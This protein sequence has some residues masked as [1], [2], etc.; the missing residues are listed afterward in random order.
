[1]EQ[2]DFWREFESRVAPYDLLCHPFY[3]AWAKGKL[4]EDDLRE[5]A[6]LYYHHV[7]RFP[8]YLEAFASRLPE[9]EL[10]AAVMGNFADEM[11]LDSP[12]ARPHAVLWLEFAEGMGATAPEVRT[13]QPIAEV[14]ELIATFRAVAGTGSAAQALATF[15]AYESQV[16][17]VAQEKERGL[18]QWYGANDRTCAYFTL[19]RTADVGHS[20]VWR[21]QLNRLL[22]E[23]AERAP[24]AL[25]AGAKAAR[26]LWHAL[27]GIEKHRQQRAGGGSQAR[28]ANC[29]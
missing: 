27:D 25:E 23:D 14:C 4:T 15:Y 16:P 5:Y 6:A 1:M 28:T 7:A 9:G 19:H 20:Q 12:A 17:R 26:S 10:R 22:A 13:R 2:R 24:E 21:E 18:R 11:G 3:Q 29:A 8:E